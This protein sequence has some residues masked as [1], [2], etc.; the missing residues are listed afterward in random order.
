MCLALPV[1]VIKLGVGPA[2][3]F[4]IG[5]ETTMPPT[6]L[7]MQQASQEQRKNFSVLGC[8]VLTPSAI[9]HI[10]E[11][12][13]VRQ[14]GTVNDVAVMTGD[15]KVVER[16]KGDGVFITTTAVGVLPEGVE[17]GGARAHPF[18][19]E[20]ALI[21]AVIANEHHFVQ[22]AF[23]QRPRSA[24]SHESSFTLTTTFDGTRIVDWLAS[25]QLPRIC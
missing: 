6:A 14:W 12:P 24:P 5:F 4:A 19:I 21:G 23:M 7:A 17:L 3:D 20:T 11:S 13:E 22:L 16:G 8:H 25:D 15:T 10:L 9:S 2:G 18:G 1:K